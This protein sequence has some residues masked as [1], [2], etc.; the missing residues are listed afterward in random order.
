MN[1]ASTVKQTVLSVLGQ[2]YQDVE[3]IVKD[4][5]SSDGTVK[6]IECVAD[7][8][9][10]VIVKRDSGLY[11]AW[12]QALDAS[13]GEWIVFLGGDDYFL[14]KDALGSLVSCADRSSS[15]FRIVYGNMLIIDQITGVHLRQLG[16]AWNDL[17]ED[18]L[19]GV[20]RVPHPGMLHHR[21]LFE[22]YGN[23]DHTFR[24]AGDYEFLL[25][26]LKSNGARYVP[27]VFTSVMRSGGLSAAE[28]A[29]LQSL[30]ETRRALQRHRL[31]IKARWYR[32]AARAACVTGAALLLQEE[33]LTQ[34]RR[35]VKRG[36]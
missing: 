4:G 22:Q 19:S 27:E 11:D 3:V 24:I 26:E 20:M 10:K 5:E 25:R 34:L 6:E 17:R 33:Q 13:S 9:V 7:P 1:V 15:E 30:L 8:R 23:F 31:P 29:R 18:F 14:D 32:A 12:N 28:S 21:S 35:L 36:R 16:A 2:T